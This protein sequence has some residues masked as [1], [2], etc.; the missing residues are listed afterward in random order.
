[1]SPNVHCRRCGR[2]LKLPISVA[3]QY[4]GLC[5]R[6]QFGFA[7]STPSPS[8]PKVR[9]ASPEIFKTHRT[10]LEVFGSTAAESFQSKLEEHPETKPYA[11]SLKRKS[12]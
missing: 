8:A 2:P 10:L 1:M 7:R 5:F 11:D 12:K 6:R 3:R 9:V 4:G